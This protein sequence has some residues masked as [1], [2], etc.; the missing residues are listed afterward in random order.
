MGGRCQNHQKLL[1]PGESGRSKPAT[2][3]TVRSSSQLEDPSACVWKPEDAEVSY[4]VDCV[5]KASCRRD[6]YYTYTYTYFPLMGIH[7][8]QPESGTRSGH[9]C[10]LWLPECRVFLL[11]WSVWP[12]TCTRI[13]VLCVRTRVCLLGVCAQPHYS[14]LTAPWVMGLLQPYIY[15]AAALSNS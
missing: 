9:Y 11:C 7:P 14:L 15:W 2:E 3:E 1:A 5:S 12:A 10:C 4:W 13:Y 8:E 6:P